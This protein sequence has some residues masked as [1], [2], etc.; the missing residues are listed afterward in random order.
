MQCMF[1][2]PEAVDDGGVSGMP[3]ISEEMVFTVLKKLGFT[4]ELFAMQGE[5]W[6]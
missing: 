1:V 5:V 6:F 3:S 4:S 2:R